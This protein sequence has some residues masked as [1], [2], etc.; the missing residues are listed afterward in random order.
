MVFRSLGA[1]LFISYLLIILVGGTVLGTSVR[2]IIPTAFDHHMAHMMGGDMM[3]PGM[4]ANAMSSDLYASFNSAVSEALLKA[5]LAAF[6]AAVVVS[7]FISRQVVAPIQEMRNASQHIAEGNY[8]QRIRIPDYLSKGEDELVQLAISFN[9]MTEQLG[10]TEKM[11][12]ELI[13][14]ISHELRTP[15]T[16]I[17]GFLEGILDGVLESNPETFNQI[18]NEADRLQKLVDDLQEISRVE[19]GTVPLD[20]KT[21]NLADQVKTVT[22]RLQPQFEEKGVAL[23]VAVPS[24]LPDVLA[25]QDRITQ[26]LINLVGNALQYT[27]SGGQVSVSAN[28]TVGNIQISIQDTGVGIPP[29]HLPHV[30]TR[31]YRV[32]KSRSRPGGG[33]GIGLTIAKHFV[34]AHNGRIWAE[35]PGSGLGTTFTFQIPITK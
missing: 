25:D 9:Q 3:G 32:D 18:Y 10:Q 28:K 31:F 23:K 14:D 19:A 35:S 12:Q 34:E 6:A 7:I 27:P 29:E 4:M 20:L 30:F 21:L 33:S 2:F 11:R 1:K 15:L 13:G 16:T 22:Q 26:I 8:G 17:K 24:N 5:G